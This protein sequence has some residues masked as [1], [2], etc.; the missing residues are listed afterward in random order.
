[1][2]IIVSFYKGENVHPLKYTI[3][4]MWT[5]EGRQI[6]GIHT[7][8][9]WLFP[10]N[11]ASAN[12]FNAPIL[13]KEDIEEFKS[14]DVMRQNLMKSFRIMLRYYGFAFTDDELSIAKANDFET[15]SGW[16]YP[17]NHNYLRI[18]RILKCLM[19]LDF[20][21]EAQMLF[22]ELKEIYRT[23]SKYIDPIT[24]QYWCKAV[25]SKG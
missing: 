4:E 19:L 1:M 25:G 23:H 12:S 15:R 13:S 10:L 11:E 18:S 16:I 3:Q 17:S 7:F 14:D 21:D 24:Y 6:E 2:S 20:Q 8:I 22:S 5:W 9:Q